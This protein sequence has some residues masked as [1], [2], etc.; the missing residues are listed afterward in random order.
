[1]LLA[2]L[3]RSIVSG[4]VNVFHRDIRLH[5]LLE[6]AGMVGM[7]MGQDDAGQPV[8]AV[9]PEHPVQVV[10]ILFLAGVDQID[11][12]AAAQQMRVALADVDGQQGHLI[13]GAAG[14][15][16]RGGVSGGAQQRQGKHDQKDSFHHRQDHLLK[17]KYPGRLKTT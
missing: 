10:I 12:I 5:Q 4:R 13:P 9:F 2:L 15:G 16:F 8:N 11:R 17:E 14:G 7:G 1:M 3:F 6:T